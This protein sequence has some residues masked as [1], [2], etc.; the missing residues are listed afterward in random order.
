MLKHQLPALPPVQEFWEQLLE[1][2]E[3][4][5]DRA[6]PAI[7]AP[8]TRAV[9]EELIRER[10]LRLPISEAV[11]SYL[12]IIRFAA[13]N[14]LCVELDY[15]SSTRMIEPYSLRRSRAG[16]IILH[17]HN[18]D[19][20]EHRSYR[21]DRIQEVRVTDRTFIPRFEIELTPTDPGVITPTATRTTSSPTRRARSS[22]SGPTYVYECSFCG[23]H[24][25]RRKQTTIL[26]PHN[27][28]DGYPVRA[29]M[30][31]G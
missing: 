21:V 8:Y 20:N 5:D 6:T 4:L 13:S 22:P 30:P 10:V 2:F 11:R 19:K 15:Q 18:V 1:F 31:S 16:H 7:P 3:W 29:D 12:E 17:A 27:D 25:K 14:R 26:N 28:Q 24:F 9:G 23:K